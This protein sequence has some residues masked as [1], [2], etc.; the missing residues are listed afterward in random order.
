MTGLGD[1]LLVARKARGLTQEYVCAELSLTQAALSRYEND[2]RTPDDETLVR[3]ARIYGVTTDFLRYGQRCHGALAVDAHMRRQK[4]VK[5]SVWRRLEARLNMHRLHCSLLFEEVALGC[6]N[7]IPTYDPEETPPAEAALLT[8]AQW[9]MPIGPVR[10]LTRWLESAGCLVIEED[11]GTTRV[12]GLSQWIGD[13]PVILVNKA[14]PVDRKRLTLAHELAHLALHS[15]TPTA[16]VE[17]EANTFAAEFLMPELVIRSELRGLS[18]G[19]LV[20]LKR[21]WGVSMQA[22]YERAY[23]LGLANAAERVTFYRS[24]NARGWKVREPAG[25]ELVP[26][27]PEL[28]QQIA[29]SMRERGLSD[30]EIASMAGFAADSDDN[31]FRLRPQRLRAV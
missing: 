29:A 31:P 19:K 12:D 24:L 13:Y 8:R 22:L 14:L 11:F 3:L 5:A 21:E 27:H 7:I 28:I 20:D 26:E 4:T 1:A 15:T 2:L 23:R 10:N 6:M 30:V 16:D 17:L 9:R 25:D 18:L